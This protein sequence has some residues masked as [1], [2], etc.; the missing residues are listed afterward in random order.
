MKDVWKIT[1]L[2]ILFICIVTMTVLLGIRNYND[3]IKKDNFCVSKGYIENYR[4]YRTGDIIEIKC[5]GLNQAKTEMTSRIYFYELA[6]ER[7]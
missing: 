7:R 5:I 6:G 1:G 3:E 2:V 4:T